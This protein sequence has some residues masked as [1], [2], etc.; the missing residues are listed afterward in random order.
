MGRRDS[1]RNGNRL[2]IKSSERRTIKGKY[3]RGGEGWGVF[4]LHQ[5]LATPAIWFAGFFLT[6]D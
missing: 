1:A 5:F 6:S 3:L 4:R 2:Y